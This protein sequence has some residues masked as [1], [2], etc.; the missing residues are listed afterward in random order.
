MPI[1]LPSRCPR[2][3][4]HCHPL[5][6]I[7]SDCETTFICCGNSDKNTRRIEQDKFRVCY[8]SHFVD[9]ISDL[10]ETDITDTISVL[11]QALS[12]YKKMGD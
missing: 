3:F 12:I 8:K 10:D 6:Q 11:A 5:A 7:I 1:E 4:V 2:S 9:D